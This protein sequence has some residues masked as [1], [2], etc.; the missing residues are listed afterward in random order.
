MKVLVDVNEATHGYSVYLHLRDGEGRLCTRMPVPC[1]ECSVGCDP[2][3]HIHVD[4]WGFCSEGCA[5]AFL[6]ER[7][8]AAASRLPMVVPF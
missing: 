8:A 7:H 5:I 6:A 4:N 1:N 3:L 2:A